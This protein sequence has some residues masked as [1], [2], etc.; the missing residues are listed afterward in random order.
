MIKHKENVTGSI[1]DNIHD[2][3]GTKNCHFEGNYQFLAPR[4]FGSGCSEFARLCAVAT[5]IRDTRLPG[6]KT[7]AFLTYQKAS[8][9][10]V[11]FKRDNLNLNY[12]DVKL[13]DIFVK[14]N[15]VAIFEFIVDGLEKS[16]SIAIP[17]RD[18]PQIQLTADIRVGAYTIQT[19]IVTAGIRD[20]SIH[21]LRRTKISKF[22][23]GEAI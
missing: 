8:G 22:T 23:L 21:E 6:F 17:L 10:S 19:V 15:G 13:K 14:D 9:A 7:E 18:A 5:Q 1:L 2:M 20:V 11:I 16:Y 4:P 3:N 12:H